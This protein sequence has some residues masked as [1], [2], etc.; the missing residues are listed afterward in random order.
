MRRLQSVELHSGPYTISQSLG[1]PVP[2]ERHPRLFAASQVVALALWSIYVGVRFHFVRGLQNGIPIF[3]WRVW[4]ALF[5]EV[6]LS[7]QDVMVTI[8]LLLPLVRKA[9]RRSRYQLIGSTAPAIDVAITCCGEPGEVIVNTLAA[10]VTQDYPSDRFRIFV[11]DDGHDKK[12]QEAVEKFGGS[13]GQGPQILNRSRELAPGARSYSKAG[14][15]QFGLDEAE[16][17]GA[18][19]YFAA[20][21]ADMIPDLDWLR[22][23]IPHLILEDNLALACPPQVSTDVIVHSVCIQSKPY[24]ISNTQYTIASVPALNTPP[25]LDKQTKSY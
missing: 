13:K 17:S 19:E 11:L 6:I 24:N 10:I 12:L 25:P 2:F 16:R 5:A 23:L 3:M 7:L 18:S 14:N 22:K 21:D 15:L 8:G 9:L 4:F 1:E 20:L